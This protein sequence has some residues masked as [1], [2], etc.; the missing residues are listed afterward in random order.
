MVSHY[1][2]VEKIGAGG[3]GEVYLAEDT[4]LR[5]KVALKFLPSQLAAD[6]DLKARFVREAEATA[7][8]DHPNI[9]T[10]FEVSEFQGRPFFAMQLVEGQ[11]LRD[12]AKGKELGIDRI[13]ELAIHIC[14][15]L[16]AAHDKKVVHRDIKPSNIVIDT[17][18]RPKILDFGLAAIQGGEPLTRTGS[19]LGTVRYMSPEQVQAQD[20]DHRSDLFSLGVVLYELI[21]GRTPF[22]K[23]NEAATLKA[24]TQDSPEPLARYKSDIPDELQRTVSK[25]LEKDPS[26]RYQSAA[27]LLSD[28]KRLTAPTQ[29][30]IAPVHVGKSNWP[31]SLGGLVIIAVFIVAAIKLWPGDGTEKRIMLAVLPFENLGAPDDEYFADGITDEITSKVGALDGIGV[32]GRTSIVLYKETRKRV[33]EIGKELNVDVILAGTI[34]WDKSGEFDKVRIN[35]QLIRVS[36]ETVVWSDNIQRDLSRIFE[37]QEEIAINIARAMNVTLISGDHAALDYRPT[38]NLDAYDDYLR[39]SNY[40]NNDDILKAIELLDKATGLDSN[41]ALAFALKSQA[42]SWSAFGEELGVSEHTKPARLAYNRAFEIQPDLAEA[43]LARG[44]YL[45]YIERDYSG[46]LKEFEVARQGHVDEAS[47]LGAI[48]GVKI[49]QG[50]WNEAVALDQQVM[51]LDPRSSWAGFITWQANWFIHQYDQALVALERLMSLDPD[52]AEYY[53][54]KAQ[55]QICMGEDVR[56]VQESLSEWSRLSTLGGFDGYIEGVTY[57]R[58]LRSWNQ[59]IGVEAKISAVKEELLR[60]PNP[61]LYYDV[62]L[63]YHFKGDKESS[64]SYIDSALMIANN[65]IAKSRSDTTGRFEIFDLGHSV[66]DRLAMGYSLTNRH[67]QAIEHAQ[68]AMEAMPIEACHF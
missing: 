64:Y 23:E 56:R 35:P 26:L 10:I 60:N 28:L 6:A 48:S 24:I 55:I 21:S 59:S 63:L 33:S 45:N 62:G 53:S 54:S 42:H 9:V 30:S 14:D 41:F 50:K 32:I 43:H 46:A 65:S 44:I 49:R 25:L 12:L 61:K 38:E 47:V 39:A 52:R 16:G 20:V 34:Q 5:R 58:L 19:T 67:E 40:L 27:G 2:I 22:E 36:D 68:L 17:Y 1:R 4:K 31:L 8:L 7:K 57:F 51:K 37:V 13:I 18:G 29:S 15:G 11:S 3:M 66:Y